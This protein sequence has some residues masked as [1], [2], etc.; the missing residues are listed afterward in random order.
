MKVKDLLDWYEKQPK[1]NEVTLD[2]GNGAVL[3]ITDI[4]D[5]QL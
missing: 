4:H 1:D 2:L 3:P 5:S